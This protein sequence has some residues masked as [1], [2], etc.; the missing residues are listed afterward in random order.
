MKSKIRFLSGWKLERGGAIGSGWNLGSGDAVGFGRKLRWGGLVGLLA[1]AVVSG[2]F[3]SP[4]WGVSLLAWIYPIPLLVVFRRMTIRRKVLWVFPALLLGHFLADYKVAPFPVP[5]LLLFGVYQSLE[6][7]ALYWLDARVRKRTDRFVAT[8]FFP[9]FAVALEYLNTVYGGGIWWS[10]ANSQYRLSWLTQLASVTGIWGI[11]FLLYWTASVVVWAVGR[12][13]KG[14]LAWGVGIYAGVL[15]LVLGLGWYR[16]SGPARDEKMVR[17]AGVTV[18]LIGLWQTFYKDYCGQRIDLDPRA[19]VTDPAMRKIGLAEAS[20]VESA[21]TV[22]F[23]NVVATIRAVDDSLFALSQRAVD[24]GAGIV[25][26]SEN[27]GIAWKADEDAFIERGQRFAAGNRVYLLMT[28]CVVNPGKITP[29]KKFLENEA[30][31]VGAEGNILTRFHK[32]NPVPL[33]EASQP[34]DG[35]IPVVKTAYGRLAV[36]ICYD[37]DFPLQMR[38]VGDKGAD[39]LLLPSGDWYAISPFHTYMAVYRGVENGCSV[40]RE[41]SNGLSLATDYRGKA[42]GSRDWFSDGR[43][44]WLADVPVGRVNTIYG[45]IGDILPYGCM[46]FTFMTIALLLTVRNRRP[47]VLLATDRTAL[48]P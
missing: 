1:V 36:S 2:V 31:L 48:Q 5:V 23:R 29:G 11:S 18:P 40:F 22:R 4:K 9:A 41:V 13:W 47:A 25:C 26:W 6:Q 30:I 21:D 34:G 20:Y 37:A 44:L 42:I 19:A 12:G 33:V 45:R 14:R 8:L 24:R 17:V 39:L 3:S 43:S 32:N 27:N 38:Q 15:A 46:L 35:I 28:I 10:V 16:Y 7:L